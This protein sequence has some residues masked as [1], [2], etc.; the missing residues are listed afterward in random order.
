[1]DKQRRTEPIVAEDFTLQVMTDS[2][3][4]ADIEQKQVRAA[5]ACNVPMQGTFDPFKWVEWEILFINYLSTLRGIRGILLHYVIR[6]PLP[7]GHHIITCTEKLVYDAPLD[8]P[9]R[10][11]DQHHDGV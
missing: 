5:E 11:S 8:G 2:I 10:F 3:H 9:A 6:K 7:E 1:M 4:Y